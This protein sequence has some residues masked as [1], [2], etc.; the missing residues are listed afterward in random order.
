VIPAKSTGRVLER[1]SRLVIRVSTD[2]RRVVYSSSLLS[3][4]SLM[5]AGVMVSLASPANSVEAM[6][7]SDGLEGEATYMASWLSLSS[8]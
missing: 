6:G 4:S 2:A 1:Q 3:E 5:N 8:R 7:V